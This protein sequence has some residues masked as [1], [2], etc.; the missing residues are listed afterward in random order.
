[1]IGN[2]EIVFLISNFATMEV[3]SSKLTN[4]MLDRAKGRDKT[5]MSGVLSAIFIYIGTGL[6]S[7]VVILLALRKHR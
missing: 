6:A 7:I 4:R 1:M 5:L 2:D 3:A